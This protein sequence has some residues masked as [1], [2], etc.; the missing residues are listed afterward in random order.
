MLDINKYIRSAVIRA[1]GYVSGRQEKR[2]ET[3]RLNANENPFPPPTSILE[4]LRSIT[5]E[6]LQR[7]PQEDSFFVREKAAEV[8][9]VKPD[10]VIIDNGSSALL[11]NIFHTILDPGDEVVVLDPTFALYKMLAEIRGALLREVVCWEPGQ[12]SVDAMVE[13]RPK[14]IVIANPMA[15]T[16]GYI[17]IEKIEELVIHASCIVVIDEAYADF[18]GHTALP[19]LSKYKNIIITRTFSKSQALAG[20]RIGLG[21]SSQEVISFINKVRPTYNIDVVKQ[22]IAIYVLGHL[23]EFEKNIIRIN[24]LREEVK[25]ALEKRGFTPIA[26]QANF[27]L[28]RTPRSMHLNAAGW[29][30]SLREK[31][32]LVRC[33][34]GQEALKDHIR[35]SIG[36]KREMKIFLRVVDSILSRK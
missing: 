14:L 23:G 16:G 7:Y 19:L 2:Q 24:K 31:G 4:V 36:T 34:P 29:E 21:F 32:V 25:L 9:G 15:P 3:I 8:Y 28:V 18:N 11:A 12:F 33:F 26:S 6:D 1:Q 22:R 10:Q 27:L 17:P 20:M 30:E 5:L 13:S 35:I